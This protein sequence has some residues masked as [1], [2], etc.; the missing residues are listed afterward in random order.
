MLK[1]WLLLSL[2]YEKYPNLSTGNVR[3]TKA[4]LSLFPP[5]QIPHQRPNPPPGKG[6]VSVFPSKGPVAQALQFL[7]SEGGQ[8]VFPELRQGAQGRAVIEGAGLLAQVAAPHCGA[9]LDLLH[10]L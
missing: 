10:H 7:Q 8:Q 6:P 9:V 5:P 4:L 3:W 1:Q 2:L